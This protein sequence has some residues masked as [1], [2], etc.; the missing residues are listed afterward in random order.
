MDRPVEYPVDV[1]IGST[2]GVGCG[3]K[4]L[5]INNLLMVDQNIASWNRVN[6]WLR[7]IDRLRQAA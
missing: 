3:M 6:S 4:S 2:S 5:R 7:Q 1:L